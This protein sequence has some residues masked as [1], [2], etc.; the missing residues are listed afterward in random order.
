[1]NQMDIL[2]ILVPIIGTMACVTLSSCCC[3]RRWMARVEHRNEALE[4]RIYALERRPIAV[5]PPVG[6][7]II[8]PTAPGPAPHPSYPVQY[9]M[10]S[11]PPVYSGYNPVT[12]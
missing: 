3:L 7:K 2:P 8:I 10:A 9:P 12:V 5:V 6:Q 1:M 4:A 11:A